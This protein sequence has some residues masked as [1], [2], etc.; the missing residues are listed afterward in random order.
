MHKDASNI[1]NLYLEAVEEQPQMMLHDDGSKSWW[2]HGQLHRRDGPA[3]DR[4]A[5]K[6][7]YLHNVLHREDGP[8]AESASGLKAWYLHGKSYKTAE[9]WAEALLKQRNEPHDDASVDA[10]LRTILKKDA[11]AAL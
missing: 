8:A 11:E 10:F 3:I 7:W 5:F 2:L 9:Q 1:F 6:A 4:G